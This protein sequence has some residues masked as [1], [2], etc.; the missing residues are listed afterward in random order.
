MNREQSHFVIEIFGLL[1][2]NS[3]STSDCVLHLLTLCI[4]NSLFSMITVTV[5][6]APYKVNMIRRFLERCKLR[7]R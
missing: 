6:C 5:T 3:V 1:F 2:S 7:C 4:P